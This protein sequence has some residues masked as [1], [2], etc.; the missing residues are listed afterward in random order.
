M[1]KTQKMKGNEYQLKYEETGLNR[2][3]YQ[4]LNYISFGHTSDEIA[5]LLYISTNTVKVHRKKLFNKMQA[6]NVA[7]LV[8][9][10]FEQNLLGI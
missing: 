9:L 4:V 3:E 5:R 7:Q 6:K 1:N 2:R 10:G 8:R